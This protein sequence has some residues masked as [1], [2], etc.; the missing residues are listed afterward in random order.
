MY[1][2]TVRL[3]GWLG[4]L[5]RRS[6]TKNVEILVLR[7]EVSV[8]RC[9]V[10]RPHHGWP[11]RAILSA[12]TRLL[13]RELRWHRIVTPGTLL[14][15][16]RRLVTRKWTYPN[17]PGRPAIGD[18]LRELI[19]RL[20]REN[21]RWGHRRVQGRTR[22]ARAPHRCGHDPPYPRRRPRRSRASAGG[23]Q[24]AHLPAHSSSGPAGYRLLPSGHHRPASP[25]RVVRDGGPHPSG[26][27]SRRD[28]ASNRS[29]DYAGRPQPADDPRRADL[30]VPVP[31]P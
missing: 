15:W 4:L 12:L 8:L 24:L 25:V 21:P 14:V 7:H 26:P 6:A 11:D 5:L 9:Q 28:R 30:P 16:H 13:P 1:L 3:F 29:L 22:P 19:V 17:Q 20:A 2:I 18:E 10:G 27:H 23:H 31:H